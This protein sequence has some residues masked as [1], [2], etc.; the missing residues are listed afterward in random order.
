MG[1]LHGAAVASSDAAR[2]ARRAAPPPTL[3]D[4]LA[5]AHSEG[6]L[7]ALRRLYDAR[8]L[9]RVTLLGGGGHGDGAPA[10][11]EMTGMLCGF[12]GEWNLLI[13]GRLHGAAIIVPGLRVVTVAAIANQ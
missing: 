12:D 10:L 2:A 11:E 5:A 3:I 8:A 4:W 6:P 7:A 13:G 9:V 1:R